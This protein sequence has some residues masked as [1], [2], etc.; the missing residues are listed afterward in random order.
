MGV[1]AKEDEEYGVIHLLRGAAPK[2]IFKQA[3]Q[4]LPNSVGLR[5]QMLEISTVSFELQLAKK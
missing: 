5:M 2:L 4:E 1:D 3:L